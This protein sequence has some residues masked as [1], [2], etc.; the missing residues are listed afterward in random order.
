MEQGDQTMGRT[1]EIIAIGDVIIGL[2]SQGKF[3]FPEDGI[4]KGDMVSYYLE[5][6]SAMVPHLEGRPLTVERFNSGITEEGFVQKKAGEHYPE[7]IGRVTVPRK[8]GSEMTYPVV[9]DAAGLV[10]L[11]NQNCVVFHVVSVHR[12]RL[13]LSDLLVIDL[14]PEDNDFQKARSAA[15]MLGDM[16]SATGLVPFVKT[17]GSRGLHVVAPIIPEE[18]DIVMEF[19]RRIAERMRQR[20]PET[21]TTEISK[22]RRGARVYLDCQRNG[23]MQMIVAPYSLRAIPGAPVSTP[24]TWAE[25]DDPALH[26]RR[27]TLRNVRERLATVGDPWSDMHREARSL[28]E[29]WEMLGG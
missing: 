5:V 2:S 8:D 9:D 27:W 10:Y 26:A 1:D 20:M 29:A 25:L 3:M 17:T 21:Y 12:E 4:T 15:R 23:R 14:D 6:A 16:L 24:L 11:S 13:T 18:P 7:W 19:G 28:A 22:Q